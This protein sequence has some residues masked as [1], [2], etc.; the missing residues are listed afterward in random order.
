M[1]AI[2]IIGAGNIG[3]RHLQAF[4]HAIRKTK[5]IV[6]DPS[7]A[8]L[9]ICKTR[10]EDVNKLNK[11]AEVIFQKNYAN[12]PKE[13]DLAIISTNSEHRYNALRNLLL[14]CHCKNILLEKFLFSSEKEYAE[15]SSLIESNKT[16]MYV[17]V[18]RRTFESYR[19][20]S[21]LLSMKKGNL[22]MKVIGN[23]WGLAS[24]SI[25]FIDLFCYFTND[26]IKICEFNNPN[27]T[28][29]LNSKREGYIEFIGIVSAESERGDKLLIECNEGTYDKINIIIEKDSFKIN[30]EESGDIISID[31]T[32]EISNRKFPYP[33]QS[34]LTLGY[35]IELIQGKT[36]ITPYH[37]SA[38]MHIKF[39][40]A[41]K[42]LLSLKKNQKEW[43][44]T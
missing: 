27:T 41:V 42:N 8:S 34:Q 14:N 26:E 31:V 29:V 28:Q 22:S 18:V 39:L 24:N 6:I 37:E 10:W 25:H 12:I 17:N 38:N 3:S 16:N 5:I 11:T 35:F 9:D 1:Y 4:A 43:K 30:I 40:H 13:I 21:E 23:N 36:S 2:V 44:I 20:V 7:Q 33:F 15:T 32:N 19:W